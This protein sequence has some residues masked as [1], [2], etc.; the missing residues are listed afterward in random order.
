MRDALDA[1]GGDDREVLTLAS[2]EGLCSD[3]VAT[4]LGVRPATARKRLERGRWRVA[5]VLAAPAVPTRPMTIA[6]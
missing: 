6:G 3:Q 4:V 1:L 5:V 2:W